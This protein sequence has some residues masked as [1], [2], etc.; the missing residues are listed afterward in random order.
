M[1][2]KVLIEETMREVFVID[3]KNEKE[4]LDIAT[5]KFYNGDIVFAPNH[6]DVSVEI[7]RK[8]I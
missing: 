5:E 7:Y 6:S 1:K 3:A 2:F 4:A 8:N